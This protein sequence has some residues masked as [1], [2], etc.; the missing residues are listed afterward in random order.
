[1]KGTK[2]YQNAAVVGVFVT[3][4]AVAMAIVQYKIPTILPV[5]MANLHIDATAGS[6]LMTI[7]VLMMVFSAIPFGILAQRFGARAISVV[8]VAIIVVGSVI[9]AFSQDTAVLLASRAVEGIAITAITVCG[10]IL[11]ESSV[12]PRD[13]GT[14]MGI[15]GTWGP[16]GSTVAALATPTLFALWGMSVLWLVYAGIVVVAAILM[17]VIVKKPASAAEERQGGGDAR[18]GRLL[19]K[20]MLL[21][22]VGFIAFNVCL[23]AVLSYVPTIL[24][25][26]GMDATT[27][28]LVST[29][30]MILSLVSSPFFGRVSDKTGKTKQLL[31]LTVAFLGP[32]AFVLY[33][34]AGAVMWGAAVVM[35]LVGMGSTGLMILGLMKV[36][37]DPSLKTIGMGALITVQGIG[38]F[39]GTFLVQL[40]LGPSFDN[41]FVA[42]AGVLVI[43]IVGTVCLAACKFRAE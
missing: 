43:G 35:G 15:W 2:N 19:T 22:F 41:V 34:S 18:F 26:R 28:G 30:P 37:P 5:L 38:Q 23:L 20:D 10:P 3:L 4:V 29:L 14:A 11:I 40:L 17:L 13:A 25:N 39:L 31:V 12:D 21:Y 16:L 33:V 27:S 9:G 8:A 6:W 1:M 7:F 24:Q 42:G 36:L 32:C